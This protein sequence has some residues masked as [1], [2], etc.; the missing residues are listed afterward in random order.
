MI[1]CSASHAPETGAPTY[2][3]ACLVSVENL[4]L[5][6]EF[7][8]RIDPVR[9]EII[10]VRT[11]THCLREA[12]FLDGRS[13]FWVGEPRSQSFGSFLTGTP[14]IAHPERNI[15]HMAFCGSTLIA[16]ILEAS[17]A[18]VVLKEPQILVDLADWRK[19]LV[20]Q[21]LT[22]PDFEPILRAARH[23]LA[24]I[25]N[26][27]A[28]VVVKPSNWA[29]NLLA[30]LSAGPDKMRPLFITIAAEPF[31]HAV[32]RGGRDR[33]VFTARAADHMAYAFANGRD[34]IAGAVL[35]S[36]DPLQQVAH[37]AALL[38][39]MQSELFRS[40]QARV[41]W[42]GRIIDFSEITN[43]PAAAA[44]RAAE[45]LDLEIP[46]QSLTRAAS[47]VAASNAKQPDTPYLPADR[48]I[49]NRAVL[50]EHRDRIEKALAFA[51][52]VRPD[53]IGVM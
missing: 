9:R 10:W 42:S 32:F 19:A 44:G 24:S 7:P 23:T 8:H 14:D 47:A 52:N 49:E 43:Q 37:L 11:T 21:G 34:L 4:E 18:A 28:P 31:L 6:I 53:P 2:F 40:A 22:D 13:V 1:A 36:T 16:R 39:R 17:D 5:E 33:I 3:T 30:D 46:S 45:I 20:R 35:A 50:D 38:H 51:A 27:G 15:F 26:G 12:L 29:N 41:D 25:G 48:E